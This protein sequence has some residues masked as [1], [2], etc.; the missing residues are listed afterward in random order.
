MDE[1]FEYMLVYSVDNWKR[2]WGI[3][4]LVVKYEISCW[5]WVGIIF[6]GSWIFGF[7]KIWIN[8]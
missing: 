8:I 5:I 1:S 4:W 2:F 6:G 7:N 3:K